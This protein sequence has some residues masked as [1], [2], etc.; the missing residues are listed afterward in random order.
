[1]GG[2]LFRLR[3]L[4]LLSPWQTVAIPTALQDRIE[5]FMFCHLWH[6][7]MLDQLL[8]RNDY[9]YQKPPRVDVY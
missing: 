8:P 2:S 4:P 9:I 7:E 1:M 3:L 5:M 6:L